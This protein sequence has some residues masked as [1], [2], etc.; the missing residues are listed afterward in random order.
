ML[1]YL[2]TALN[3][4]IGFSVYTEYFDCSSMYLLGK[5]TYEKECIKKTLGKVSR[6]K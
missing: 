2:Q 4:V 3:I 5:N 6:R 1:S